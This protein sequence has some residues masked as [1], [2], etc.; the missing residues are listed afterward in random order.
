M[1]LRGFCKP[2]ASQCNSVDSLWKDLISASIFKG[3]TVVVLHVVN[4]SI[5]K[6]GNGLEQTGGCK[7]LL[8]HK[9][10]QRVLC[11]FCRGAVEWRNSPRRIECLSL[12]TQVRS[13]QSL[14]TPCESGVKPDVGS[15]S[16]MSGYLLVSGV[17]M[18]EDGKPLRHRSLVPALSSWLA[19]LVLS[20]APHCLVLS[21]QR[22]RKGLCC[23][24]DLQ[25]GEGA[26]TTW[27]LGIALE[28]LPP[29]PPPVNKRITYG[30]FDQISFW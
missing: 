23:H 12:T 30:S 13:Q 20:E 26:A 8:P 22:A 1:P 6:C 29:P 24:Y 5:Q 2:A 19:G 27:V 4:R 16:H 3:Q 14:G 18:G 25:G 28:S 17:W 7:V 15:A 10:A 9:S 11:P 21:A